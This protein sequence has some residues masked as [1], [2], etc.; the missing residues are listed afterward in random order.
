MKTEKRLFLNVDLHLFDGGAGGGAGAGDGAGAGV[1][2]GGAAPHTADVPVKDIVYGKQLKTSAENPKKEPETA[3]T[4]NTADE[5]EAEFEKLIKGEYKD[6]YEKRFKQGLD[7]RFKQ[8]KAMEEQLNASKAFDP[9]REM[10]ATKYGVDGTDANAIL[11][12]LEED[13]S[14][15]EEEAM[16]KGMSIEQVKQF[17]KLERENAAFKRSMQEQQAR[18]QAAQRFQQLTQQG[19]ALKQVYPNFDLQAEANDPASGQRFRALLNSGV[20]VRTAYEVIHMNDIMGGAMQYTAQTIQQKTI[21]DIRARG[22]RPA[23]NGAGGNAAAAVVKSDPKKFT[24]KDR[25]EISRRVMRGER[26][27]L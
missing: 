17:H 13:N 11:K 6:L 8:Q 20:D 14:F 26:I 25:D 27:E 7:A 12:A 22:M 3:I 23:E 21:N 5:R 10:L 1:G 24:R 15:Y 2:D 16:A 9:V 4:S 18:E 19:E